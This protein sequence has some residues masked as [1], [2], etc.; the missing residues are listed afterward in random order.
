M[1]NY[2]IV[3]FGDSWAYGSGL[4][5]TREKN[6]LTL[7]ADQ[8]GVDAV[9]FAVTSSS[10]PHLVLQFQNF[11][12]TCYS[13]NQQYFA[14]FFVTAKE[15]TFFIDPNT[16]HTIHSS[17]CK[18][19]FVD[20][21]KNYYQHYTNHYQHFVVNTAICT[22]EHLCNFYNIPHCY[23][24]GW[25]TIDFWPAIDTGYFLFKNQYPVTELFGQTTNFTDLMNSGCKFLDSTGHPNQLGHQTIADA[26][27]NH[28]I[29]KVQ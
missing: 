1:D 10:I 20:Q 11:L 24:P 3:G 29:D 16:G 9:N 17:P 4:D 19:D 2:T 8:L 13:A 28:I 23:I 7:A 25:Q 26:L 14:V 15:R 12:S 21:E 18:L 27:V 22:L 5:L 6:Y